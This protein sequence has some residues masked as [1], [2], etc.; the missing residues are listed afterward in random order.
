[1]EGFG[2]GI[3]EIEGLFSLKVVIS[4]CDIEGSFSF[5]VISMCGMKGST[6]F[7]VIGLYYFESSFPF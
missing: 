2:I 4:I 1:M 7:Q 5:S 3:Y 6:S